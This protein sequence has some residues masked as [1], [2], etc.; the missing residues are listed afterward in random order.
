MTAA[1]LADKLSRK[2]TWPQNSFPASMTSSL[3][4]ELVSNATEGIIHFLSTTHVRA[5]F[6][7]PRE[8]RQLQRRPICAAQSITGI[9]Q[10][11]I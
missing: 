1:V 4:F 6:R 9:Q 3:P 2:W 7:I 10:L 5:T 8:L 11:S